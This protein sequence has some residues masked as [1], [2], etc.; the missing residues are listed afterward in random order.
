MSDHYDPFNPFG[1]GVGM[2]SENPLPPWLTYSFKVVAYCFLCCLLPMVLVWTLPVL[3]SSLIYN[4]FPQRL[5]TAQFFMMVPLMFVNFAIGLV[6]NFIVVPVCLLIFGCVTNYFLVVKRL[7]Y[8]E[9]RMQAKAR[10][11]QYLNGRKLNYN[12]D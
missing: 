4:C 6:F 11:E 5:R 8:R 2:M 10:M 3:M 7:E 1:C 12:D 9:S